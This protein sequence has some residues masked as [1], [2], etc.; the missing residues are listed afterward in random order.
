M[1]R[2]TITHIIANLRSVDF[3]NGS[4]TIDV[5]GSFYASG[6]PSDHEAW[7]HDW[8]RRNRG[9]ENFDVTRVEVWAG[10]RRY[11]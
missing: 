2:L 9:L 8:L 11:K 4:A 7:A 5:D 3:G 6:D 1:T 10:T